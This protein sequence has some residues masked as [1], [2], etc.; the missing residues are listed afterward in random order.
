MAFFSSFLETPS[1]VTEIQ[2]VVGQPG[3]L[4]L[5]PGPAKYFRYSVD[6]SSMDVLC[7]I[8]NVFFQQVKCCKFASSRRFKQVCYFRVF[9][10][11][12]VELESSA[13]TPQ[14]LLV[15]ASSSS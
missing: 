13:V 1:S 2:N 7:D 12:K 4:L 10:L 8:V 5:L 9:Q 6:K 11:F 14:I 3:L 15:S